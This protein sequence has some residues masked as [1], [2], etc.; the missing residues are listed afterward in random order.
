MSERP[1]P[2]NGT[3]AESRQPSEEITE[4]L[5]GLRNADLG[6]IGA[7]ESARRAGII[8]P[9][10]NPTFSSETIAPSEQP[11][12]RGSELTL[13]YLP[14]IPKGLLKE[15]HNGS[16]ILFVGA[17][18]WVEDKRGTEPTMV[19]GVLRLSEDGEVSA[20]AVLDYTDRS[21]EIPITEHG[22]R[23]GRIPVVN[24][25]IRRHEVQD[26]AVDPDMKVDHQKIR[27]LVLSVACE[28]VEQSQVSDLPEAP[29]AA[30]V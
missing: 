2:E 1:D 15:G 3:A 22:K 30:A 19:T 24:S 5:E 11:E 21:S 6:L 14:G 26:E 12:G 17:R 23:V 16:A 7:I 28:I 18:D 4:I 13:T 29:Q 27:T 9:G 10:P 20:K 25:G 8:S